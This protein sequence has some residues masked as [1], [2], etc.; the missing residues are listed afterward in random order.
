MGPL[1]FIQAVLLTFQ[2]A[3]AESSPIETAERL[4]HESVNVPEIGPGTQTSQFL[5]FIVLRITVFP[6]FILGLVIIL[7]WLA[8]RSS[9]LSF[10]IADGDNLLI[11]VTVADQVVSFIL[12]ELS[13]RGYEDFITQ[14]LP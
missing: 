7:P 14:K 8:S 4:K 13:M 9:G 5:R 12:S 10:S 11:A 2:Y 1:L 6:A 3:E